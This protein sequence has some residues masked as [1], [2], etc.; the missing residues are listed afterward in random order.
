MFEWG[1]FFKNLF[2]FQEQLSQKS[3]LSI[4]QNKVFKGMA[5]W[6]V[7]APIVKTTFTC[8]L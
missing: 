4:E 1:N 2:F 6:V 7:G 8:V 5:S 3:F